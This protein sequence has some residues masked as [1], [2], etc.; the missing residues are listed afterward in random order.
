MAKQRAEL[1][2]WKIKLSNASRNQHSNKKMEKSKV[3]RYRG[4]IEQVPVFYIMNARNKEQIN[5]REDTIKK[6]KGRSKLKERKTIQK[7]F[8][9]LNSKD[10]ES[11]D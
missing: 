4:Y 11:L 7:C 2:T 6:R 10:Y 9:E 5:H 1:E 8:P 3:K